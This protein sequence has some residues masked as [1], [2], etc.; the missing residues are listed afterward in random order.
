VRDYT[1]GEWTQAVERAGFVIQ[2]I[3]RHQIRIEFDSWI[4]RMRTPPVQ[5]QAVRALQAAASQDV[6][7]HF[8]IEPDGS[9]QLDVMVLEALA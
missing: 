3:A 5:A 8:G 2:A 9:F 1:L 7:R 4:A 6:R